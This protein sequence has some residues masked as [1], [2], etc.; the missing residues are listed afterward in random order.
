MDV[1]IFLTIGI[2]ISS[3]ALPI[4][5]ARAPDGDPTIG[6]PACALTLAGNTIVY[7]TLI[8]LFISNSSSEYDTVW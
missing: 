5:L 4:V 1:T 3:F 6:W 8:G 7:I 2:V